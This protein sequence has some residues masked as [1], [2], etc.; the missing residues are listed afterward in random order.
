MVKKFNKMKSLLLLKC[1]YI[2]TT[3]GKKIVM[4]N[5]EVR[6]VAIDR[7]KKT[8][9]HIFKT[10]HIQKNNIN[11]DY[12]TVNFLQNRKEKK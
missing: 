4:G 2:H 11:K 1:A 9:S 5:D 12:L 8:T 3:S 6:A 7:R 10:S